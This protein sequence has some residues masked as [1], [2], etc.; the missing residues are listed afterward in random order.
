[1]GRV[2][3]ANSAENGASPSRVTRCILQAR[4]GRT[5][6]N[7]FVLSRSRTGA[8]AAALRPVAPFPWCWLHPSTREAPPGSTAR[9]P[10]SGR[11]NPD[12]ARTCARPPVQEAVT[13]QQRAG[14]L[15]LA[16]G[17]KGYRMGVHS[18]LLRHM[19]SNVGGGNR[20]LDAGA[21]Q[22]HAAR[23]C[24]GACTWWPGEIIMTASAT[25]HAT[26]GAV[27]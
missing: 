18:S 15:W 19:P 17:R 6:P 10:G 5:C 14:R 4:E 1:M 20:W 23:T 22:Q 7:T 8:T 21:L 24:P 2:R 11:G 13:L 9:Q 25:D 26:A 12:F 16:G 27:C 3:K